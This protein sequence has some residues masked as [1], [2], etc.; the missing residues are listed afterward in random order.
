MF[1]IVTSDAGRV[2]AIHSNINNTMNKE[3]NHLTILIA[4]LP[5]GSI[6][7]NLDYTFYNVI[8]STYRNQW[9]P[10]F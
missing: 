8:N 5:P 3:S 4:N 1:N 9:Y 2:I 6:G 10:P 7:L